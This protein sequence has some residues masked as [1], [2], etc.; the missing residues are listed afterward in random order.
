MDQS[1]DM[2]RPAVLE[3]ITETQLQELERQ[4]DEEDRDEW[5]QLTDSYGWSKDDSEAVWSWFGAQP[6]GQR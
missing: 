4:F 6:G 2:S 5:D 3:D 1:S